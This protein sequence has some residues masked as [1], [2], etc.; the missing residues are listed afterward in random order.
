MSDQVHAHLY[1]ADKTDKDG[2]RRIEI[3]ETTTRYTPLPHV[4]M[5]DIIEET[6][7]AILVP[8]GYTMLENQFGTAKDGNRL[9]GII[10]FA[11]GDE[12]VQLAMGYR[13]SYDRSMAAGL[14]VGGLVTVCSNLMLTG[15]IVQMLTH[16]GDIASG[17][18]VSVTGALHMAD[19]TF[20]QLLETKLRLKQT[21]IDRDP[22]C[23]ILGVMWDEVLP[24]TMHNIAQREWRDRIDITGSGWDLYNACTAAAKKSRPD[25][26]LEI[27]KGIDN[28]FARPKDE[29]HIPLI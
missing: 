3:P 23:G 12:E 22:G 8:K 21:T 20:A 27:H 6:A 29:W 28:W 18:R 26:A 19:G 13:N 17:L 2:L 7:E 1:G 14:A 16:R 9:F 24:P 10:T 5:I 11:N 15:D 25:N 4:T